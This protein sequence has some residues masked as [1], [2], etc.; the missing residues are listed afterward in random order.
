V[1]HYICLFSNNG[2]VLFFVVVATSLV[3]WRRHLLLWV[4]GQFFSLI[5]SNLLKDI[6]SWY[7]RNKGENW[8]EKQNGTRP[9][10][11]QCVC[12]SMVTKI[13]YVVYWICYGCLD[14]VNAFQKLVDLHYVLQFLLSLLVWL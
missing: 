1:T 11:L 3:E 6:G 7:E 10:E 9:G 13:N 14:K 12:V 5:D 2:M 8:S 4:A